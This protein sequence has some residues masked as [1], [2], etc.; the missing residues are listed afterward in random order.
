M[1][2]AFNTDSLSIVNNIT[3]LMYIYDNCL[4]NGGVCPL[5]ELNEVEFKKLEEKIKGGTRKWVNIKLKKW[6]HKQKLNS[7]K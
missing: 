3:N 6:K 2:R 4:H 7:F 5:P 1:K